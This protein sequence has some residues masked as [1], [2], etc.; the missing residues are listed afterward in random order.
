MTLQNDKHKGAKKMNWRA[1]RSRR[2][3]HLE[4]L[5]VRNAPSHFGG[6]AHAAL[7]VHQVHA[8][9][10][11][12]HFSD[13]VAH[14]RVSSLDRSS[15]VERSPDMNVETSSNDHSGIGTSPNDQSSVDRAG[16]S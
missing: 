5:E 15:G 11:V 9:A 13:S 4:S 16:R 10:H 8:A 1:T 7:A 2:S 3:F 12:R 6:L 14:D